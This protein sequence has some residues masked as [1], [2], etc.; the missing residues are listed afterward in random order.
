MAYDLVVRN[1]TV[2][3]GSCAPRRQAEGEGAPS[4]RNRDLP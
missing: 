3:D 2:I 1:G 4:R